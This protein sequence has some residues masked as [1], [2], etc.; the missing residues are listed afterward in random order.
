M[1]LLGDM[2]EKILLIKTLVTFLTRPRQLPWP[3][4]I[5]LVT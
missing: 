4:I 1:I 2:K 3:F 5:W